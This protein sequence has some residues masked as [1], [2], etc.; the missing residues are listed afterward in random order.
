MVRS[1]LLRRAVL[2]VGMA[3]GQMAWA[4]DL[5]LW[6]DTPANPKK[7]MAEALPIGNGRLGGMV[8]GSPATER[9]MFN[10]DSLWTGDENPT[11]DYGKMG[12]YQTFGNVLI[13][14][15]AHV[16]ATGLRRDLDIGDAIAHVTYQSDGVNFTR[17][18]FASQP[19]QVLVIRMLADKPGSY[20]GS[21]E[22]TDAHS[23]MVAADGDRLQAAGALSNGMK[24]ESQVKVINDGGTVQ[25]TG[26]K[27][28]FANCNSLTILLSA[29]TDYVMD[30]ATKYKGQ[31]P[32][33]RVTDVI[34]QASGK[35]YDDLKAAHQKDF[36]KYFDRVAL[37]LGQ[38]SAQ[39]KLLTTE[40][41][42]VE[43]AKGDDPELQELLFQYGRYLLISC[44]RPGGLPANLQG[45]WNDSNTPDWASDYHTNINIE[46]NY[47][48]AEVTNLSEC[49]TPLFDLIQSQLD[50]WRKATAVERKFKTA[51]GKT[52]GWAVRTS[53]NITGGLGWKWDNTANAWYCQH[54]WEHYAFTGDKKYLMEVAYPIMKEI[55]EF[56]ED[57]LKA[58]PDGTLV[59]PRAWSPEHGPDE[60]GV[61][62]SQQIVWDLFSNYAEAARVLGVD[63]DY[64]TKVAGM[65]DKL[66]APKIGK[67]GQLQEWMVDRDDPKDQHRHTSHLFGVYPGKQISIAKTPELAAAAKVSLSAR[68]DTGDSRRQW[69]WAWRTA[70]WARFHDGDAAYRM[71]LGLLQHNTLPN[72]IGNHPPQQWDGNFGITAG[73]A[74]MLL[75]SHEGQLTLLPALPAKWPRG[76]VKGLRARGGVEVD[77]AWNQGKLTSATLRS[78]LG[79]ACRA[80]AGVPVVVT[81]NGKPVEVIRPADGVLEWSTNKGDVFTLTPGG[82]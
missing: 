12:K 11:G 8:F 5:V 32:H 30:S 49:H 27:V 43:M 19:D 29:G 40:Q 60:D 76:S 23:A 20:T 26:S 7:C 25:I 78:T 77:M 9:V 17:E 65:R 50:P 63:A 6:Y 53:H 18:Y 79:G 10:E 41:R 52:R 15:P 62:Y 34:T 74:E 54:L 36:K 73:I 70:L 82:K 64:A 21:I 68:G 22:L 38:S 13:N 57:H 48:P 51:N 3:A 75:Q 33:Q 31:D 80:Q 71:I 42:R 46:M 2:L 66:L 24:Y 37:D 35:P 39:K 45:L 55:C 56:W 28:E 58:L 16:R 47:W 14:L 59:V 69:V 81:L 61:S 4:S 67:W 1:D 44:S 72:L